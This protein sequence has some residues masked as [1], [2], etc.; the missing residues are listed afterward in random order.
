MTSTCGWQ[1]TSD[2]GRYE[3]YT[4]RD[5]ALLTTSISEGTLYVID[6]G[7][8]DDE[9]DVDPPRE[10]SPDD[11]EVVLFF[12]PESVPTKPEDGEGDSNEEE[13]DLQFMAY[14]SPVHMH[15]VDLSADDALEF[16]N[17]PH[18]RRD[19]TSSSLDSCELKVG[20]E[21]S[22]NDGF[23]DALKQYSIMNGVNYNMIKFKSTKFEAKCF[24]R[25]SQAGFRDGSGLNTTDSE[26][27]SHDCCA[28][29][30][31]QK[32][33]DNMHN[34]WEASYN[35]VWQRCQVLEMYV[36]GYIT[37]LQTVP[38]DYNDRLLRGYQVF[39]HLY[40]RRLLLAVVQY[41]DGRILPITFVITLGESGDECD[42]F[43]SKLRRHV[44]P[45]PDIC[46]ISD[47]G[48]GILAII[49]L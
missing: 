8:S 1:S 44:C 41:G 49:E 34:G 27:G 2:W 22:S 38:A 14:L 7:G 19:H 17:V 4:I 24:T 30:A 36:P 16:P 46:F 48:A 9:P 3:M 18:M 32:A 6:V 40:T 31:K 10:A 42:F 5:D 35:E 33:L 37:D 13:E 12:E 26:N 21:F 15:N 39:K 29:V 28:W 20:K 23:L 45:Q 25:S 11:T 47:R 43:L